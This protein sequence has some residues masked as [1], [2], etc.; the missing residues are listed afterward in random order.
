M[1]LSS[2]QLSRFKK[3][4]PKECNSEQVL[5]TANKFVTLLEVIV[6]TKTKGMTK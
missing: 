4:L 6:S 5:S 3:L 2:D 1:S